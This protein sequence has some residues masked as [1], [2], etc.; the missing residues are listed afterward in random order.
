M[1]FWFESIYAHSHMH[2]YL[3]I[4]I[5]P[6]NCDEKYITYCEA[7][8]KKLEKQCTA[9]YGF[10]LWIGCLLLSYMYDFLPSIYDKG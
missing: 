9:L 8:S 7:L 6:L 4:Y 2:A 10:F 1:K 3:C 5:C